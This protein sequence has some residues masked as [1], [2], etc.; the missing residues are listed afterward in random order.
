MRRLLAAHIVQRWL[1]LGGAALLLSGCGGP[2]FTTGGARSSSSFGSGFGGT[3]GGFGTLDRTDSRGGSTA[4]ETA[5]APRRGVYPSFEISFELPE[6]KGNPFDYQE[7]DVQV[8]LRKPD[9]GAVRWPAFFD[10]NNVWRL[11]Y[12]PDGLGRYQV[13]RILLNGQEV[14]AEKVSRREVDVSGAPGSGYIRRDD[15]DPTRFVTDDGKAY[16]PLGMNV[17]WDTPGADVLSV[18]RK[19]GANGGNWARVWMCHWDNK[20]LDWPAQRKVPIGTL[21]L[22]VAKKWDRIVEAAEQAGVYLQIVLQH[23]G[24]YST[25]TNPNWAENPW[26]K[27]NGGFLTS[28]EEFFTNPRAIA[29]TRAK[30]RY[31]IARWAHSPNVMAWEL[32]NEVEWTDAIRNKNADEVAAW[33]KGMAAFLREQDPTGR[34][35][36]TSSD[37]KIAR[38]YDA[39]DYLQPHAYPSDPLPVVTG[40]AGSKQAKPIFLGE[41]GPGSGGSV[42]EFAHAALWASLMTESAGAAQPW[43][44]DVLHKADAYGLYAST[45]AF[46]RATGLTSRRGLARGGVTVD[47]PARAT[48]V[49]GPGGGFEPAGRTEFTVLPSGVV[50]PL[51]QMPAYLQGRAHRQM[52]PSLSLKLNLPAPATFTVVFARV[53]RAGAHVKAVCGEAAGEQQ[54][55]AASADSQTDARIVLQLPAG[56]QTVRLENVGADWAQI[57]RFEIS[58]YAAA[59]GV[60]G[61][62]GPESAYGWLYRRKAEGS[63]QAVAGKLAVGGL[64]PGTY[65]VIWW[66]TAKGAPQSEETVNHSKQGTLSIATPDVESDLAVAIVRAGEAAAGAPASAAAARRGGSRPATSRR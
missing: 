51:T 46:L 12:A 34:L 52:F 5:P 65:R 56:A 7:N 20:N 25:A 48:L 60:V 4:L 3:Y 50:E 14:Q 1:A 39:M 66:N 64:R 62:S 36:T 15:R 16:Y 26:N 30:Y 22:D 8:E 31:I 41:I 23:H 10:G 37:M 53:A 45:S 9:G 27:A 17:G 6:I 49:F 47:T 24:Q 21:D 40:I 33:H 42:V 19:L 58:N 44:W 63:S 57:R 18:L 55:P 43:S 54:F 11:R 35:V 61:K 32:F 2:D 59:L 13:A 28:P 38:L 29:L